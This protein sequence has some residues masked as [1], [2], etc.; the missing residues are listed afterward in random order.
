[1]WKIK[2]QSEVRSNVIYGTPNSII[3][4]NRQLGIV[5]QTKEEDKNGQCKRDYSRL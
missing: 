2:V 4:L 1:M 3:L 5:Y